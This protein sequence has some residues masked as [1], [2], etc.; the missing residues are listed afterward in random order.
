M[1]IIV[2]GR[3]QGTS[4]Y[5]ILGC[6]K[7]GEA[8]VEYMGWYFRKSKSLGPVRLN[9]SKSGLGVSAGVKGARLSVGPRGIYV[10]LGRNGIYYRKQIGGSN[11]GRS[12][13][14]TSYEPDFSTEAIH[15]SDSALNSELGKRIIKEINSSWILIWLWIIV[16]SASVVLSFLFK[17]WAF[18][19]ICAAA[20][21]L[22]WYFTPKLSF[23]LD[24]EAELE[25]KKLIESVHGLRDSKKLW[26]V[27]TTSFNL[28]TKA[29]AGAF[30]NTTRGVASANLVNEK[31][32][33]GFGIKVNVPTVLIQS[34][35]CNFLFIPSGILIKKGSSLV[36]YPYNE[37][38]LFFSTRTYIETEPVAGDAEIIS[39]RWQFV[40]KDG[41]PDKRYKNNMQLP[42]CM[43]GTLA[44]KG[45]ELDVEL[46]TS[47]KLVAQ[48]VEATYRHYR[49]FLN[50]LGSEYNS[51][52][53]ISNSIATDDEKDDEPKVKLRDC[54]EFEVGEYTLSIRDNKIHYTKPVMTKLGKGKME[55]SISGSKITGLIYKKPSSTSSG[56]L[57]FEF[58]SN[59]NIKNNDPYLLQADK[60]NISDVIKMEFSLEEGK[61]VIYLLYRLSEDIGIPITYV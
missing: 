20:I 58:A 14:N 41:S 54:T 25:W 2:S 34:N 22:W 52:E 45:N 37:V 23:D 36:A 53:Q 28:D 21:P 44:I 30:R 47:N 31:G 26:L 42:V 7:A 40:N 1:R 16:T 10:N 3:I 46:L 19:L 12:S 4:I 60:S 59:V 57:N 24:S 35:K 33:T 15:V 55:A 11:A 49:E 39:H 48:S 5:N 32:Y 13:H 18:L 43:Y 56:Y 27:E 50:S 8:K 17:E 51:A 61:W 6:I 29:N 38:Y 9:A